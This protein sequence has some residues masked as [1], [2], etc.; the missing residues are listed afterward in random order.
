MKRKFHY[1]FD[2]VYELELDLIKDIHTN[3]SLDQV[4]PYGRVNIRLSIARFFKIQK[5]F[6]P[7]T[8]LSL[9][10]LANQ[11]LHRTAVVIF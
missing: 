4:Q 1:K 7:N 3:L 11:M 2:I 9:Y 5:V 10:F 8:A 6:L